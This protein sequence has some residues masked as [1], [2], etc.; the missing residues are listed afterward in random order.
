MM[1]DDDL[2]YTG[3]HAFVFMRE[4]DPGTNIRDVIGALRQLDKPTIRYAAEM[5]GN[6][7]DPRTSVAS[8]TI[9]IANMTV[10]GT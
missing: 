10:A 7:L 2:D 9:K 5:V 6:D 8:P 4:V 1:V 3:L